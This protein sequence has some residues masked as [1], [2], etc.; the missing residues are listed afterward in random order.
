[1]ESLRSYIDD[2]Y[3]DVEGGYSLKAEKLSRGEPTFSGLFTLNE[4]G[5]LAVRP[6][7]INL[8]KA[9]TFLTKLQWTRIKE[10]EEKYGGFSSAIAVTPSVS[11]TY[12]ALRAW[13][14]LSQHN[15]YIGM[16]NVEINETAALVY[17]NRTYTE[18]GSFA[19]MIGEDGDI[20]STYMAVYSIDYLARLIEEN[21]GTPY[22][23][24]IDTWLNTTGVIEYILSCRSGDGFKPAPDGKVI[25]VTPTATAI[26]TLS[27]LDRLDVLG[28]LQPIRDWLLARQVTTPVADEY[29]GG[30]TESYM[31][32]DTNLMSTYYAL[33]ALNALNSIEGHVNV[34][35]VADFIV[36][37]QAAD[38]SW[39]LA[40]NAPE[41]ETTYIGIAFEAF[42]L[43]PDV[44]PLVLLSE[45]D[46]NNPSPPVFDWRWIAVAVPL[47][48]ALVAGIVALRLD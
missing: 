44:N 8:T 1:M 15:D 36:S 7:A 22:Q 27:I 9:K 12:Y 46:P 35:S 23:H 24:T 4:L 29:V 45:E 13:Q 34:T 16:Q 43:L 19:A 40:P 30:F 3:D 20:V 32:N 28:D 47:V 41:G 31:T 39:A 26:L 42:S 37:C 21:D 25:G 18:E 10:K 38:G 33:K 14:I 11:S 17:L 2:Q 6:P 5:D 48:L